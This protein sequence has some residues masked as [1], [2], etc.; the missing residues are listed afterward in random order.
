VFDIFTFDQVGDHM[1]NVSPRSDF[2]GQ[3]TLVREHL[4]AHSPCEFG[5]LR[6]APAA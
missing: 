6:L 5:D 1:T 2:G 4:R 3:V